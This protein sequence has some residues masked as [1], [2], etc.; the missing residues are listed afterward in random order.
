[1]FDSNPHHLQKP[2]SIEQL[3]RDTFRAGLEALARPG[4]VQRIEALFESHLLAMASSLLYSKIRYF[5]RGTQADFHLV[6]AMTG[7]SQAAP[8]TS[9]YLFAD[10]PSVELWR[11]ASPGSMER[12]ETSA[13]CIFACSD[14]FE[15]PVILRGPGIKDARRARLPVAEDFAMALAENRPSFPLGADLFLVDDKGLLLGLPRTTAIEV[16]P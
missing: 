5:Y 7:A 11:K 8:E 2:E 15:T 9:H 3:N 13:T 16:L 6:E 14:S 10:A 4:R 12:P 1:M